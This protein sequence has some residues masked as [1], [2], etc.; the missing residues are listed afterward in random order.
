MAAMGIVLAL[1]AADLLTQS[2]GTLNAVQLEQQDIDHA[3]IQL[4]VAWAMQK[5][6][7][8]LLLGGIFAAV[9]AVVLASLRAR[10]ASR[11]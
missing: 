11:G 2:F 5:Y 1:L 8:A 4:Q 7:P 10:L 6:A 9:T 3:Y